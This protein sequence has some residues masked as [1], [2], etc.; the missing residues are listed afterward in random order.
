MNKLSPPALDKSAVMLY[1]ASMA[2][3]VMV[4]L[5][6]GSDYMKHRDV[7]AA[8]DAA[9]ST[10]LAETIITLKGINDSIDDRYTATQAR[11]DFASVGVRVTRL[12]DRVHDLE[13]HP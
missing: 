11:R 10:S 9:V 7:A 8:R 12:E 2:L 1:R 5:W 3:A 6:F 4:I 13:I